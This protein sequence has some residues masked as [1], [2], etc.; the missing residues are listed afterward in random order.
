M[1]FVLKYRVGRVLDG[2]SD[3]YTLQPTADYE[4]LISHSASELTAKAWIRTG[5]Q[6][7]R[8]IQRFEER[9][10]DVR[11]KLEQPA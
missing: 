5:A 1:K 10:P 6:M 7:R 3:V 8:A 9:N 4:A 11:S 2:L